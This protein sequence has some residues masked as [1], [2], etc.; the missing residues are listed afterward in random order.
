M[1]FPLRW[2]SPAIRAQEVSAASGLKYR[3]VTEAGPP[4]LLQ[5]PGKA[6]VS[7]MGQSTGAYRS[8]HKSG[9][10]RQGLLVRPD[11]APRGQA[12]CSPVGLLG[13]LPGFLF[14]FGKSGQG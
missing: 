1:A 13:Y 7:L 11:L 9:R 6:A 14:V 4:S 8:T 2:R 5:I 3:A 12:R 10:M